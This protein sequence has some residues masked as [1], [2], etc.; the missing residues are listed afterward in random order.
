MKY[1]AEDEPVALRT[2]AREG[3][4]VFEVADRG[5]GIDPAEQRRI[6][7]RFY[8]SDQRLSRSHEGCGLGLS[9]VRSVVR[10]HGGS[11]SVQSAPGVGSTFTIRLPAQR[12][13]N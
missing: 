12:P 5:I 11:V 2:F 9:I 4:I 6:F 3:E 10:A 13:A 8:Q 1:S 7:E